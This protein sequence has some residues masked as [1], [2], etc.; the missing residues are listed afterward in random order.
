MCGPAQCWLMLKVAENQQA[1]LCKA[2]SGGRRA[3]WDRRHTVQHWP[4]QPGHTPPQVTLDTFHPDIFHL[5]IFHSDIFH[6]DILLEILNQFTFLL[7]TKICMYDMILW[8]LCKTVKRAVSYFAILYSRL[9]TTFWAGFCHFIVRN[10]K[11][12]CSFLPSYKL[13]LIKS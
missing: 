10:C 8:Y 2:A 13:I 4:G 11:F 6:L 7:N 3:S 9:M 1:V 12:F 5:D